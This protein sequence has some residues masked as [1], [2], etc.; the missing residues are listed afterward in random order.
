MAKFAFWANTT[1]LEWYEI[2]ARSFREAIAKLQSNSVQ[3]IKRQR[4]VQYFGPFPSNDVQ[5]VHTR[6]GGKKSLTGY[7]TKNRK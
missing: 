4:E 7:T 3:P 2:E 5:Y 6:K 1:Y